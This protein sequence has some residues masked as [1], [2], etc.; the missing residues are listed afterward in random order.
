MICKGEFMVQKKYLVAFF[1]LLIA[2]SMVFNCASVYVTEAHSSWFGKAL[3]ILF[4]VSVSCLCLM[5]EKHKH[6]YTRKTLLC[7]V[8][9]GLYLF[10]YLPIIE[11]FPTPLSPT[12]I[13]LQRI[14]S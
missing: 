5:S 13:V 2:I 11:V 12:N 6:M 1:E 14:G 10:I 3:F 4:C 7:N 9:F 8:F